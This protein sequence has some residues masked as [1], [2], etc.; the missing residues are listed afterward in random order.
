M[1]KP[2][3]Y[4]VPYQINGDGLMNEI[5]SEWGSYFE[6]LTGSEKLWL[7]A[8]VSR[9]LWVWF[10]DELDCREGVMTAASRFHQELTPDA[11]LGILVA[12]CEQ[13]KND[14]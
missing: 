12:L 1:N 13:L 11:R 7:L 2:I 14:D 4:Y 6:R 3:S 9:E 8:R 5:E 10:A